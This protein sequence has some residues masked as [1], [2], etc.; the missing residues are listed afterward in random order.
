MKTFTG[1]ILAFLAFSTAC[2][3][4]PSID[5]QQPTGSLAFA[6]DRVEAKATDR[7][8]AEVAD[9]GVYCFRHGAGDWQAESATTRPEKMYNQQ[10]VKHGAAWRY[11][12]PQEW[13]GVAQKLS[14]FGYSPYATPTNQVAVHSP[15]TAVGIPTLRFEALP[16]IA[17]QIDL[18]VSRPVL[19]QR[20][21][22]QLVSM[23]FAHALAK[24]AVWVYPEDDAI[25][26][27]RIEFSGIRYQG[28][29]ELSYPA[30]WQVDPATT[31]YSIAFP[32]PGFDL[33]GATREQPYDATKQGNYLMTVPQSWMGNTTAKITFYYHT[34]TA[35]GLVREYV[36]GSRAEEWPQGQ[37][38][39]YLCRLTPVRLTVA[40]AL[41]G[42]WT[43]TSS[44]GSFLVNNEFRVRIAE[45]SIDTKTVNRVALTVGGVDYVFAVLGKA[46]SNSL[47]G[48]LDPFY[49]W[50]S[51]PA[52]PKEY[53]IRIARVRLSADSG[54]TW[55]DYPYTTDLTRR[56]DP[57]AIELSR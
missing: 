36:L 49:S 11:D 41:I 15:Q 25:F 53:P 7:T 3:H 31:S 20:P 17:D 14:F 48:E 42:P 4:D 32:A 1:V 13:E 22:G 18:L 2:R 30:V 27:D 40:E 57:V 29:F 9:F 37:S 33:A 23:R 45:P 44:Q 16:M 6:V 12:P 21:Q 8:T 26:V 28:V 39:V 43:V 52:F 54:M 35:A 19:N 56:G 51:V 46:A 38:T 10:V 50:G 55:V 47:I 24:V 34:P 5:A